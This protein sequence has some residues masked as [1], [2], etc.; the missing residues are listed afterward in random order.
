[1]PC[2]LVHGNLETPAV[3]DALRSRLGRTDVLAP[4]LPGFGGPTP[5]GFAAGMEDYVGWLVAELEAIGAPVD[6]VGHDWG[7]LFVGRVA[8]TRPDL[9]R[10]WAIDVSG[11]FDPD[12][13]WHDLARIWQTPGEGE[14]WV[15]DLL[16][17][18]RADFA[19]GL[20]AGG[21]SATAATACAAALSEDVGRAM[22]A[23]YRSA[24]PPALQSWATDAEQAAARPG[25]AINGGA[26]PYTGGESLS[27][28]AAGRMGARFVL[29]DGLGHWWMDEDPGRGA[30]TLES[31]WST[32]PGG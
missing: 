19:T 14:R 18:P 15:A 24:G 4:W 2:V 8:A 20:A 23:L 21:L 17:A 12:Y 29:L 28:R 22:L 13:R 5:A 7:G 1:M 27:R 10:S 16:A 3:W 9:L 11:E 32:L 26:D 6:L 30:D 31:F 25:L